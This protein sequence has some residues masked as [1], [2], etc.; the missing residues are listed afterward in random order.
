MLP[1][2]LPLLAAGV[3]LLSACGSGTDYNS[4]AAGRPSVAAGTVVIDGSLALQPML[5]SVSD[6]AQ[7]AGAA[8]ASVGITGENA[9]FASL[10]HG[11]IDIVSATRIIKNAEYQVCSDEGYKVLE[12]PIA[13]DALAVAT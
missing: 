7:A 6:H 5:K 11:D 4:S 3:L 13:V 8:P 1:R 10:C 9:A 12:L 2:F